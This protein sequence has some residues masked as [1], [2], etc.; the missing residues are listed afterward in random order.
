ML[1][2]EMEIQYVGVIDLF[3]NSYRYT[4]TLS[5]LMIDIYLLRHGEVPQ[6]KP[7]RFL[8]QQDTLLTAE[9]C[10]QIRSWQVAFEKIPFS[11]AV[12]SDLT[13]CRETTEIALHNRDVPVVFDSALREVSLGSWEGLTIAQVE[14]LFPGEYR[15]RGL[16][17]ANYVPHG[18]ESFEQ[19][20]YRA[21]KSLR[22]H[23][24]E[25]LS[26]GG[27]LL[28]VTHAGVGRCALAHVLAMPVSCVMRLEYSYARCHVLR[29]DGAFRMVSGMN[30]APGG[31]PG[32]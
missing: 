1:L 9:G 25:A 21:L 28:V 32:R 14:T 6:S 10:A 26:R 3:S 16:D 29:F 31:L 20:R 4:F 19:L 30:L 12:S 11:L 18:G 22:E 13:R 23:A 7:R 2:R 24:E 15:K 17:M 5:L 27:P 8:G